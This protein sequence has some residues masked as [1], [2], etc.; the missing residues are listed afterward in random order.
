MAVFRAVNYSPDN[1]MNSS[2]QN[3]EL[4]FPSLVQLVDNDLL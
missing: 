1:L 4:S 2:S 3:L